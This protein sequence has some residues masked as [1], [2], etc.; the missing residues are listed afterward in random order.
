MAIAAKKPITLPNTEQQQVQ[1]LE[2]LLR[3]GVPALVSPAGER[4]ELPGTVFEVLRAAVGFM[5]H[6]QTITL[7]PDKRAAQSKVVKM[8]VPNSGAI[9]VQTPIQAG[10]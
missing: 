3:G 9:R 1:A 8:M 2:K 6:G 5:S 10:G 4:I 7:V